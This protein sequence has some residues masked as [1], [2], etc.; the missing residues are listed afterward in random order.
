MIP[1]F[2]VLLRLAR[3][4]H[5]DDVPEFLG[6]LERIRAIAWS[7][8]TVPSAQVSA[9]P[10]DELVGVKEASRRLGVSSSYL[11]QHHNSFPFT[12]RVGRSLRFSIKGIE[13]Y[14]QR[15]GVLT[16][17]RHTAILTPVGSHREEKTV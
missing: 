9:S 10:D 12:R 15:T 1:E 4:L 7:R 3:L 11:Y 17:R 2:E 8:L 14:I 6:E 16:P 13:S 5:Q